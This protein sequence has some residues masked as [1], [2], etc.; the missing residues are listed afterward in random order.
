VSITRYVLKWYHLKIKD[1]QKSKNA[2]GNYSK[3]AW[4]IFPC[5]QDISPVCDCPGSPDLCTP[6]EFI[7]M[8]PSVRPNLE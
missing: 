2:P 7:P 4:E 1:Y 5:H 6:A 3:P 8:R